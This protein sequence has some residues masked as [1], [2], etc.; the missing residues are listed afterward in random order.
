MDDMVGTRP[1]EARVVSLGESKALWT[2]CFQL[3]NLLA[4]FQWW[5]LGWKCPSANSPPARP[6]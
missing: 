2:V 4:M 1:D 3:T 6:K 5:D